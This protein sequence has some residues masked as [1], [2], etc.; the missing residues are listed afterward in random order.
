MFSCLLV[1]CNGPLAAPEGVQAQGAFHASD[2]LGDR[3]DPIE[4]TMAY[5]KATLG[6]DF[7]GLW[8]RLDGS[9]VVG[10]ATGTELGARSLAEAES[11]LGASI[12]TQPVRHSLT[13]LEA[14]VRWIT[15]RMDW[16]ADQGFIIYTVGPD[17]VRN[18]VAVTASGSADD[19]DRL[20]ELLGPSVEVSEGEPMRILPGPPENPN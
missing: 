2:G 8:R 16:L 12:R 4:E 3:H 5:L 20:Q 7:G 13:E 6:P 14:R 15:A 17:V 18:V 19:L 10:V 9:W 1:S 11:L